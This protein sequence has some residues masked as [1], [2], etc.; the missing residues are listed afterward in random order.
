MYGRKSDSQDQTD[1]STDYAVLHKMNCATE[2]R[3]LLLAI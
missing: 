1:R 2:L 3:A